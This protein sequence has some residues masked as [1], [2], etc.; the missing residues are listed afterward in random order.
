MSKITVFARIEEMDR[1]FGFI[2]DKL[3]ELSLSTKLKAQINIA[4]DEIFANIVNYAY[5]NSD[6]EVEVDIEFDV[7]EERTICICFMDSGIPFNPF[8]TKE[9]DITLAAEERQIGGLGFYMVKKSM[10]NVMYEYRDGKNKLI[11]MKCVI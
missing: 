5:P 4:V 7:Q 10:D 2:E 3:E 8:D 6:G 11:I 9:P 1:V